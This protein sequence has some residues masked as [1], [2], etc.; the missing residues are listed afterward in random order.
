MNY[1]TWDRDQIA[2]LLLDAGRTAMQY[3]SDPTISI[4][5]DKSIVTEAD[6]A[7]E[8]RLEELF[9][10]PDAG[11]YLLGEETFETH[12]ADYFT[13]A[14]AGTTWIVDPIDG[15]SSF[16]FGLPSWGV[17]IAYARDGV[18]REGGIF[19]P[20]TGDLMITDGGRVY[21]QKLG[22]DSAGWK[23]DALRPFSRPE[24]DPTRI[25][26]VS[27]S[28]EVAKTGRY[29]GPQSVHAN[30][31]CVFSAVYLALGSFIGYIA[32][33]KL[34]DIAAAIAIFDALGF[35][36]KFGPD[37]RVG[38]EISPDNYLMNNDGGMHW[39]MAG[40]L[41]I[42][43]SEPLCDYLIKQVEPPLPARG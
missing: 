15:T 20:V 11:V 8:R 39:K 14:L 35:T 2:G 27:V 1:A 25:G 37:Q 9:D 3:F 29:R 26:L 23:A 6:T 43:D 38:P 34:W 16:A 4:K 30:G 19:L 41:F 24:M 31:S 22:H 18:I 17:S 5:S 7:I 42:A 28:Q 10:H 32:S 13:R 21:A 33:V 36:M 40:H 12:D